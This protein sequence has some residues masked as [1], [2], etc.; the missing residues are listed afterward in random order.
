MNSQSHNNCFP[1]INTKKRITNFIIIIMFGFKDF[2]TRN[3]IKP[4]NF[5]K[6]SAKK[7]FITV[8]IVNRAKFVYLN[9]EKINSFGLFFHMLVKYRKWIICFFSYYRCDFNKLFVC[10]FEQLLILQQRGFRSSFVAYEMF[11]YDVY[12]NS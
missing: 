7:M 1:N 5:H 12:V 6:S 10:Y 2:L 9:F 3:S 4:L 8:T 11:L